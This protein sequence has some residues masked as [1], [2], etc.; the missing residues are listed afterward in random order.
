MIIRNL[1]EI[2]TREQIIQKFI[3]EKEISED[4]WSSQRNDSTNK[5]MNFGIWKHAQVKRRIII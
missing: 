1:G 5:V 2:W 3:I 4:Y